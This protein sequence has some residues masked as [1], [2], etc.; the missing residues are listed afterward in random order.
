MGHFEMNGI[1]DIMRQLEGIANATD[2]TAMKMIDTA[3]PIL[4]KNLRKNVEAAA[5]RGY[6]TGQLAAAVTAGKAKMNEFGCY[7]IVTAEGKDKKGVRNMEKLAYLE[8]GTPGGQLAHP[9]MKKSINESEND[10]LRVMQQVFERET[11]L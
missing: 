6:A 2:E 10:C 1:D 4:E 5:N 3:A 8:Y 9:V 7:S 11:G